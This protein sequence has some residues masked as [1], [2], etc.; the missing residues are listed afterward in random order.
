MSF[1]YQ[2]FTTRDKNKFNGLVVTLRVRLFHEL[3]IHGGRVG[4][5]CGFGGVE[6]VL[7]IPPNGL[8]HLSN[9]D[10]S[11]QPLTSYLT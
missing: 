11:T 8:E 6:V 1:I 7:G 5:K 4:R 10:A 2:P 9:T 3:D